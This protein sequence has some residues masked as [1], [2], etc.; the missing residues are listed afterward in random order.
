MALKETLLIILRTF[1]LQ[2]V[3]YDRLGNIFEK[4]ENM[5]EGCK[6][7]PFI[8]PLSFALLTPSKAVREREAYLRYVYELKTI[9]AA[10]M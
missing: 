4:V 1:R 5:F 7:S 2:I 6:C 8:F 10:D 3:V 9:F